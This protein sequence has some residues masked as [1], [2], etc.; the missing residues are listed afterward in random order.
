[1]CKTAGN[2]TVSGYGS[3]HIEWCA[4]DYIPK[5]R[6]SCR[7][8]SG[9]VY[10]VSMQPQYDDDSTQGYL[11][12]ND[13]TRANKQGWPEITDHSYFNSSSFGVLYEPTWGNG[14]A[15]APYGCSGF[16]I[17]LTGAPQ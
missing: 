3:C 9:K 11:M 12:D 8:D 16:S 15:C 7:L 10:F 13:G 5:L 6:K 2:A 17:S 4:N 14:G 1:M